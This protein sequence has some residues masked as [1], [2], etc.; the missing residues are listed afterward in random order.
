MT[1]RSIGAVLGGQ[2]SK[3]RRTFQPVRRN[4]YNVGERERL[5]WK[6]LDRSERRAR[7]AAARAFDREERKQGQPWGPLGPIGLEL[8]DALYDLIDYRSGRLD[9]SINFL[10]AKI[11]RSKKAVIDAMRRLK[12]NGFVDWIRR[13]EPIDNPGPGPQVKQATNAYWFGLPAKAAALVARIL[14]RG[15]P[16]P[17]DQVQREADEEASV[18][19][20]LEE[21]G[22]EAAA[23]FIAGDS[24]LG[25][26]LAALGRS[27]GSSASL[28]PS[29]ESPE[30]R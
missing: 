6:P 13:T 19:A 16:K 22:P 26:A 21:A 5:I 25:D 11:R 8:L 28:S 23:R 29:P 2:E 17:D 3:A 10:C 7:I 24:P 27:L 30:G 20:M 9:P 14:G 15:A 1:A 4:S 18:S 12:E